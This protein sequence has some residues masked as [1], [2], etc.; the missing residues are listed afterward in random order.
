MRIRG[1]WNKAPPDSDQENDE[2]NETDL[3]TDDE[4]M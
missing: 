3:D 4:D 1:N 2:G